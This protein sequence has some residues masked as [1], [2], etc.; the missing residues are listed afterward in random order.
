[1]GAKCSEVTAHKLAPISLPAPQGFM[2]SWALWNLGT[3]WAGLEG[4]CG[5]TG[6]ILCNSLMI[7]IIRGAFWDH[8]GVTWGYLGV[9]WVYSGSFGGHFCKLGYYLEPFGGH[10]GIIWE[11]FDAPRGT[12]QKQS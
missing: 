5:I 4:N 10:L 3:Y 11:S 12:A 1:M 8:F 9:A 6:G 7:W 2:R